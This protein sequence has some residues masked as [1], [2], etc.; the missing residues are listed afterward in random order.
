MKKNLCILFFSLPILLYGQFGNIETNKEYFIAGNTVN[1]RKGPSVNTEKLVQL[2]I[3]TPVITEKESE[4]KYTLNGYDTYWYK[5][6]TTYHDTLYNG[7]IWGGFLTKDTAA[8]QTIAN[9]YYMLTLSKV[10]NEEDWDRVYAYLRV[11]RDGKELAKTEFK[12]IGGMNT[13]HSIKTLG[14][15]GVKGIKEVIR[16]E[17]SDGYCGGAFGDVVFFWDGQKLH[18]VK[19][20]V[21]GADAPMFYDEEFIFPSDPGGKPGI[22]YFTQKEGEYTDNGTERLTTNKKEKYIWTGSVLV[23]Q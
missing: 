4:E 9:T 17:F 6:K 21:D 19:Q 23:K 11:F 1:M 12:V 10:Q 5:V 14:D 18:Y 22:I 15:R 3:G 20:L 2:P 16:V 13:Y 7:Y 8:S